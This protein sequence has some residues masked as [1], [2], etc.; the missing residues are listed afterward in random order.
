MP[1]NSNNC[2][3][4]RCDNKH[5]YFESL[6]DLHKLFHTFYDYISISYWRISGLLYTL[7]ASIMANT[8]KTFTK[9]F[10][11]SNDNTDDAIPYQRHFILSN[12]ITGLL[13][14]I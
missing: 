1:K 2:L 11:V 13:L 4:I 9:T 5:L 14:S 10:T 6:C 12:Q 3:L 7:P 8:T